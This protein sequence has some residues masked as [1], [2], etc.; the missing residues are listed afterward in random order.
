[1]LPELGADSRLQALEAL[2]MR[3]AGGAEADSELARAALICWP[4]MRRDPN[5]PSVPGTRERRGLERPAGGEVGSP[6]S[7]AGVEPGHRLGCSFPAG[8]LILLAAPHFRLI[9]QGGEPVFGLPPEL[10]RGRNL[11]AWFLAVPG[12]L[13][14]SRWLKPIVNRD[15]VGCGFCKESRAKISYD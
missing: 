8:P 13:A 2:H 7:W 3:R 6:L 4:R 1:M 15:G 5:R 12:S 9:V 11:R 10:A 14:S